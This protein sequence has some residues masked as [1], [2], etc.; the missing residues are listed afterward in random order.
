MEDASLASA[1]RLLEARIMPRMRVIAATAILTVVLVWNVRHG[2]EH[3]A[4][5]LPEFPARYFA[6]VSIAT[7]LY[8]DGEFPVASYGVRRAAAR[9]Q[10]DAAFDGYVAEL[11][12]R[13]AAGGI[14]HGRPFAVLAGSPA[15]STG[16]FVSRRDDS[17]RAYLL[18]HAFRCLGGVAP[19]LLFWMA[20][21]VAVPVLWWIAF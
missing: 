20:T 6:D 18:G 7:H 17:G 1:C 16:V 19:Y 12:T 21:L 13:S 15:T 2:L 9:P 5:R 14:A 4:P 8:Q 3:T 10:N 11:A